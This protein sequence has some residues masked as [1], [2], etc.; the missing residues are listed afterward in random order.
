MTSSVFA[1]GIVDTIRVEI[2]AVTFGAWAAHP[3]VDWPWAIAQAVDSGADGA[4]IR[5]GWVVTYIATGRT[6]PAALVDGLTQREA[7]T[8][9]CALD[10]AGP[11]L[12]LWG[13][14][15]GMAIE[16]WLGIELAI[17][18]VI[19]TTL[20]EMPPQKSALVS[21]CDTCKRWI[22]TLGSGS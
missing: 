20:D 19:A 22:A 13:D 1:R 12:A 9:A 10:D 17:E 3:S 21:D 11:R 4:A 7:E 14:G 5:I 6:L 15:S 8:I 18:A 16:E 2:P